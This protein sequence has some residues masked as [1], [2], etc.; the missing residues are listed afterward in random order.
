MAK[1]NIKNERVKRDFLYFLKE[2]KGYCESTINQIEREILTYEDFTTSADF[3]TFNRE[4]AIDFKKCLKKRKFREK[5]I[6]LS[7][8][9]NHLRHLRKFFGWLVGQP[10]YKNK[11]N[12]N[13]IAYLLGHRHTDKYDPVLQKP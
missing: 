4:K 6:S 1:I 10:G 12:N 7:T 9:H 5:T 13:D 11:I 3:S 2:A 8:Y